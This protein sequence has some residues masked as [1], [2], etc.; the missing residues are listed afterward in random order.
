M[1]LVSCNSILKAIKTLPF[2]SII[3]INKNKNLKREVFHGHHISYMFLC[4]VATKQLKDTNEKWNK[5]QKKKRTIN[6]ESSTK[7]FN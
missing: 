3:K 6:K 5:I 2:S 1:L 4:F 7:L